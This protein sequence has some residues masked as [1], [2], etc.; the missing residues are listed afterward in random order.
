MNTSE[1]VFSPTSYKEFRQCGLKFR[2]RRVDRLPVEH[3]VSHYRWLGRLIHESIYTALANR[4]DTKS[5]LLRPTPNRD[6]AMIAYEQAWQPLRP[7]EEP[8]APWVAEM[9]ADKPVGRFFAGKTAPL[10]GSQ[11]DR[12]QGWRNLGR[13]MVANGISTMTSFLPHITELE[14]KLEWTY[15]DK[16]FTGYIDILLKMPDGRLGFLDLKTSWS[17]PRSLAE[18]FQFFSYSY[19]LKQIHNLDYYPVGTWVHLRDKSLI[20]AVVT[21]EAITKHAAEV[22]RAMELLELNV[23]TSAFGS[24]LCKFCDF[25]EVCY[26]KGFFNDY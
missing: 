1:Y 18:D 2:Y 16:S 17:K 26:G 4:E 14:H 23:Y 20:P 22:G 19:A 7:G 12:E 11:H 5:Y 21:P 6:V 15:L 8:A 25:R 24:P 3:E 13:N 10:K 9:F